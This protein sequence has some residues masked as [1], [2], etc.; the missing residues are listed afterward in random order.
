M[1]V[2]TAALSVGSTPKAS[3][4]QLM[5]MSIES[6]SSAWRVPSVREVE[7]K[8]QMASARRCFGVVAWLSI[9]SIENNHKVQSGHTILSVFVAISRI[10]RENVC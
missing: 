2:E 4:M 1:A 8:S 10:S 7:R 5:A 6:F 9:V 3:P